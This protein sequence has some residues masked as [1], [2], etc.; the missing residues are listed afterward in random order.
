MTERR[1]ALQQQKA[2]LEA[3]ARMKLDVGDWHGVADAAMD[4]REIDALLDE[5]VRVEEAGYTK[6]SPVLQ[7]VLDAIS[8]KLDPHTQIADHPNV[9]FAQMQRLKLLQ[10]GAA[11]QLQ[12]TIKLREALQPWGNQAQSSNLGAGIWPPTSSAVDPT[13]YNPP[14]QGAGP[15]VEPASAGPWTMPNPR[16]P[17]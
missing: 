3:Y 6:D 13:A 9:K 5:L 4:I 14:M 15:L 7:A 16:Q 11:S 2:Q 12:T 17:L 8:G 10:E 1:A